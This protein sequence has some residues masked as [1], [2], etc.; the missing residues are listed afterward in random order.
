MSGLLTAKEDVEVCMSKVAGLHRASAMRWV[1]K[2]PDLIGKSTAPRL[3]GWK[4]FL[5]VHGSACRA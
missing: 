2:A 5:Q 3:H 4:R 1:A